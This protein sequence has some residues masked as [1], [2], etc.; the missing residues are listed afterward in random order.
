MLT[1]QK[2]FASMW[3]FCGTGFFETLSK[4]LSKVG[5]LLLKIVY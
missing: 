2:A 1:L 5:I 4:E 3:K